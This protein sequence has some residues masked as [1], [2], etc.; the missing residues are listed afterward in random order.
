MEKEIRNMNVK[1]LKA[2]AKERGIKRYYWLRKAQLIES[3]ETET[4]PTEAP[5]TEIMEAPETEIMEAPETEIMEAP[6]NEIME[7]PETEIMEAP[8]NEIMEA[9]E[10][11]IMEAPETEI[12]EA[13]ETEIMEAPETEIMEARETEIMEAPVPE[14]MEAPETEIMEAPET[15]I[16]DEPVPE[17]KKAVLSPTKMENISR[18]SSLVGLAKKQAD[19]VQKAINKFA[20]WLIN[21]IP[22]PI[23]RTVNTRVEKLKK[24]I[25]E[26]LENKKKLSRQEVNTT[27]ESSTPQEVFTN[28]TEIKLVENG[29]RVKVYKT[30]G[31]LNF[32]LTDKIM[33]KITPIIETRTTVI[34]AFSCVIYRGQGE[35]I[36]YSKTFKAPPGTFSSLD[37]IKEYIR[38]CEQKRLDLEDAETWSK[39]YL[40]ATATYN[41]KGVYE[42]RVRFTSVSTKIILSNEPLLGCGPLPK[43]LADKKCSYAIDK[44]DDNLCFWRCLV[45]HQRIMKGEKRP[46]EKT[47]RD[48]LKL[49]RDFYKRPNLKRGDV[50]PTRLVDFENIAKQF[51]VNIRLFE[52]KRNEDKTAWRLVFGKNQ[53]KKNLPCVDI[54]LFVYEDHDEKQAEKDNRYLRQGHC[55][56]IKDIELLT[57]TWECVGCGQRFNRHDNYNR[58]VTGGTC[59]GG[60]T[61]LICPGEKFE[62]IMS[63]TE[64]VFYGGNTKFSYAACQWIEK[65]SELTGRH[66]HHALCGHG[67][68]YY[69]H[70]YAGKEKNSHAREIPVDGYEPESNTIFQYHGCKWHGCPCQKRKERNS[71]EEERIAEERSADQRYAKTI[72]LEKKMKEQGFKIVSVWECEKPELKK[73]RFCKKFRPYPYF[74]VYDFEAICQKIYEKQTDELEI[75]AKHIPVSVAINDNLTKKPS[76]IVEEDPKELN[77]KFVVELLK[78][79]REIEEKVGSANYVLG[80]RRKMNEED[81]GDQYGGYLINEARVKLSK[82]TAKSYVN[83]VKQVPVFGFNSGRY[84]INMIKEYFVKNLTSLSDV[85]VAKK[86]N[87]YMFL[88]TPNFKFL[89]IKNFLAPGLSYDAWCRAYGCELQ[90]LAFPYEWFD[91]FE[92]LNHIGPVKYEEFYSSLK[93]GITI[94][95]EEYQN[96]CDEFHKRGC[97]T[98]KDW[99]KEYNLADVE[100]FIE[101]LEKTR[102]QYYPDEIDLLKDAV[103]IPGISMTYVLNKALKIKKNSDP[104]LFAP[105]DP[106]K[107][108]CKN[109]CQKKGCEKCK[110]IRDN[111]EICTKNEAY[112]MLTTGMIGGPSIVFCRHAEAGVS[113]IRSHIYSEADAKTCRSVQGLDANSLYLFC[114]G[115]EMPCGKEKVFHCDPEE[116]DKLIQNV[117][118]DKLFGFFEVDKEVPEQKRKRFS[119]FC[120]LFV[121]SEVT[122]EQIPQHMKDY[123]INTGRKM[124]KNSKKLLGV[125]KTEKVLLYSPL[126]K[127]YLNHGLQVTKIHRYISYTPGTPFK[128][129]PEEVSSARRD[130]DNDKNKKQLGDTAKLKGNSFYGKMI[131]NLE[132][133]ISTKF[134]TDEKLIDKIFRSPFFEDLE[135]INAGVF[136][137][138][139]RK[140]QVT[141][142]RPYQC[143]IAVYQLAKLRMLEFYYDFLDKFCDRR[144]FELIQMDTDSFYMALSANDFDEII[145]PEMKEL[146]KEEKKNWLVTDEYSKRVPGLFKAEFQGKRMIAL[147]SK[148]YFADNGKDEGVKKFSCKGVSRRQNKMNWERYKNALFGSL[149]K[150]RNIGFRKRDNHIVTYEQSK[151]GLSAYYDKRIVHEDG[152]HTSCL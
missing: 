84:D 72:E 130:A 36:E 108:K 19:L 78:R 42:G 9:P 60:K 146:Y 49:A 145:K 91:S 97:V 47:N 141:I 94:S 43:W 148:C 115:Q 22:A 32:D 90:K 25:K 5:E 64:K 2:L 69:V 70:L 135:E 29:G 56:F 110:E 137:V 131:G 39:A 136:E 119:E 65:Q 121:I 116:K 79:A 24:Q 45:I 102:E 50:K 109:D 124:I 55:F 122:E 75:T 147:T 120:P 34:Q 95:Q 23:R 38:Q 81:K 30:T 150:A 48:A 7:A 15:E 127:W 51:K 101:A 144:D 82:E 152:I 100:P 89:D 28:K 37:D 114:S 71:L 31:N 35:I 123:K 104:D 16:M 46:E 134:T 87:S 33:E 73:K 1:E 83:W 105:G 88:S 85:N 132:K 20:D 107:C 93:G 13:R 96:F 54:G 17:I 61:K 138:R 62:R 6:E 111:C 76:F 113:K 3:L 41:S 126:L 12:M 77:K 58:H 44:I 4:P 128:W 117:L 103:S 53:F 52:P 66:I 133:H 92:K 140:R 14:I 139:Q 106:C 21:Y 40:P 63:S 10:N 59:D 26:I 98:M 129:F 80:V 67:G 74:I 27:G 86:E 99:L 18:V 11:E 68:E 8:E 57:K 142:T 125:M 118:N 151:L 143:G 149:D 112:E